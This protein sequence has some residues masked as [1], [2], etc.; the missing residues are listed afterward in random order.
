MLLLAL[1]LAPLAAAV[2][3][4]FAHGKD[5]DQGAGDAAAR[6]GLVL[7]FAIAALGTPL[8]LGHG[9]A[10]SVPWFAL[11]GTEAVIS[12]SLGSDGISAW[13][14]Q[15]VIWLTP[16]AILG[17]R[18]VAGGRMREYVAAIFVC[19]A[20]M[21]GALLARDLVL[22]YICFEAMLLPILVLLALFGGPERRQPRCG[23]CS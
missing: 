4:V 1:V 7:A 2:I 21:I 16:F 15:L 10:F 13:L 5:A 11:P 8:A 3:A 18:G 12:L 9:A 14:V 22:F 19:E 20:A 17:G 6:L 23:S